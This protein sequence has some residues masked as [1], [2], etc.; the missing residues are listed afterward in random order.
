[1]KNL[2]LLVLFAVVIFWFAPVGLAATG[3]VPKLVSS[4]RTEAKTTWTDKNAKRNNSAL[5]NGTTNNLVSPSASTL[6]R[7]PNVLG[8]LPDVAEDML[9]ANGLRMEAHGDA[10]HGIAACQSPTAGTEVKRGSV[11]IVVF[12][13]EPVLPTE[14]KSCR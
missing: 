8:R 3:R 12:K 2:Q 13:M 7:V 9:I 10:G 6:V 1:M 4:W 11:V 14:R 5:E